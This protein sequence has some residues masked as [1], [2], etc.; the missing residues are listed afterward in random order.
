MIVTVAI[1]KLLLPCFCSKEGDFR[2]NNASDRD[3]LNLQLTSLPVGGMC[4]TISLQLSIDRAM[5]HGR[6]LAE[7]DVVHDSETWESGAD[8]HTDKHSVY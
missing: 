4:V 2:E 6:F 5:G 3:H 8:R 1:G 7:H